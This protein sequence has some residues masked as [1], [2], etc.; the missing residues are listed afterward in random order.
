MNA[1]NPKQRK[2]VEGKMNVETKS[3]TN[4]PKEES[5]SFIASFSTLSPIKTPTMT[6]ARLPNA[7][8]PIVLS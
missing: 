5:P 2:D 7:A 4:Q 6:E 1:H 8:H 3:R